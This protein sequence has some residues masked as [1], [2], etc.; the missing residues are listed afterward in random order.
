M[1]EYF[2]PYKYLMGQNW[3]DALEQ[4]LPVFISVGTNQEFYPAL[5]RVL[6]KSCANVSDFAQFFL[7]LKNSK[8]DKILP[9]FYVQ[10][11]INMILS[12]DKQHSEKINFRARDF[13]ELKQFFFELF[14]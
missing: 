10:L 5:R 14:Y 1:I 13:Y 12:L 3:D 8:P 2:Y 7:F 11:Y 6:M 9:T 4:L